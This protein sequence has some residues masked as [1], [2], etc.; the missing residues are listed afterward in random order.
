MSS[1]PSFSSSLRSFQAPPIVLY[2]ALQLAHRHR[3]LQEPCRPPFSIASS[4]EPLLDFIL[5]L[6]KSA[7]S[8]STPWCN[9]F[10]FYRPKSLKPRAQANFGHGAAV[11][12]SNSGR[13]TPLSPLQS[14]LSRPRAIRRP[15]SGDTPSAAPFAKEPLQFLSIGPAVHSVVSIMYFLI[16]KAYF[17]LFRF[18]IRFQ[19]ITSLPLVLYCS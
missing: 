13:P 11:T 10:A 7:S 5:A 12:L 2:R 1:L 14:N 15:K 19:K 8:S 3:T 4:P 9:R 17:L 6:G 16:S 18:K